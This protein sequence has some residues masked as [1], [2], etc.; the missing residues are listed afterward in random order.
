MAVA[1]ENLPRAGKRE[2]SPDAVLI[3]A[4]DSM[5]QSSEYLVTLEAAKLAPVGSPERKLLD[6]EGE[7]RVEK[8]GSVWGFISRIESRAVSRIT[9][10][11]RLV[12]DLVAQQGFD[13]IEA[14][15][16]TRDSIFV[17][18]EEYLWSRELNPC[19]DNAGD[20]SKDFKWSGRS[21]HEARRKIM[22]FAA[23]YNA[24]EASASQSQVAPD[25]VVFITDKGSVAPKSEFLAP[26]QVWQ[27]AIDSLM[28]KRDVQIAWVARPDAKPPYIVV[29][30]GQMIH[31]AEKR[32]AI[33]EGVEG[34]SVVFNPDQYDFLYWKEGQ[35]S[36][37]QLREESRTNI[38]LLTRAK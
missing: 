22:E 36:L 12:N 11:R 34:I 28:E 2:R 6:E 29:S 13:N 20:L 24:P 37:E 27:T 15:V 25:G 16:E 32:Q 8:N 18:S 38:T 35:P 3:Q 19:Y 31:D 26:K 7:V 4:V 9:K 23:D 1:A 30:T 5:F 17:S 14:E 21:P 33:I 10:H